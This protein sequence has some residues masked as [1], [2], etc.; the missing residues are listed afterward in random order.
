MRTVDLFAGCGGLSLG[1]S[2]A[3]MDVVAAYE[4]WESAI[5]VYN[6]NFSH[7]IFDFDLSDVNTAVTHIKQFR[8]DLIA[9][10]PPCQDFSSAGKRNE[11]GGRGDLTQSYAKIV[12]KILPEWFLME[13]VERINKSQIYQNAKRLFKSAGYGLTEIVLD[14]SYCNVPQKRKRMFLIGKLNEQDDYLKPALEHS[15]RAKSMT[16]REYFGEEL[17]IE[18]YYRHARSYSRRGI[19]SVDEP[20]PTIRGVNRPIP[21]KYQFHDGDAIK[22]V[23]KVRPLTAHER[24]RIQTF[25]KDFKWVVTNK[26][27]LEQLIGNAVPVNLAK[28]VGE[29]INVYNENNIVR[30][31]VAI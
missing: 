14:A 29:A 23:S 3:G 11:N 10:G 24:A 1:L 7:P 20:S 30:F 2:K 25:P 31:N 12:T 26:S 28:F 13:N 18:Y 17:P 16:I 6:E 22:D 8:P 9:G 4:K 19:F 27:T 15:L 5:A 21:P